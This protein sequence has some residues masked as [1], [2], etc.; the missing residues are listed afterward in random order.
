MKTR[1]RE[2]DLSQRYWLEFNERLLKDEGFA[3]KLP[4]GAVV[5]LLPEN[6]PRACA[7]AKR[8]ARQ[9]AQWK[10]TRLLETDDEREYEIVEVPGQRQKVVFITISADG[11]EWDILSAEEV[12]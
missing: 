8:E 6:D 12:L 9:A 7:R 10:A 11:Q 5:F 3:E 2:A 1:V 4:D